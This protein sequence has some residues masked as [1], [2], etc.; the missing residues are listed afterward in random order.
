[1]S[2]HDMTSAEWDSLVL[3]ASEL[4]ITNSAG[5]V[6]VQIGPNPSIQIF[7]TNGV[8]IG[9]WDANGIRLTSAASGAS[10]FLQYPNEISFSV[11]DS[12]QTHIAFVAQG[13]TAVPPNVLRQL[14]MTMYSGDLNNHGG[15]SLL[16]TSASD[17]N[18][19]PPQIIAN[20]P[21]LAANFPGGLGAETWHQVTYA[22]NWSDQGSGFGKVAY[23][24]TP[25]GRVAF[26]G[27]AKLTGTS[28][29]PATV[30]SL[31]AGYRPNRTVNLTELISTSP[32][33]NPA[34]EMIQVATNGDV[35]VTCYAGNVNPGPI[36]FENLSFYL[37][38][39]V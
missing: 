10:M 20:Y 38:A 37:S 33:V 3:I 11:N 5:T 36:S 19:I 22:T 8:L 2:G 18:S 15:A 31:P 9:Q 1:M 4:L 6:L 13:S 26:S 21:I 23:R 30:F 34:T 35:F 17:D 7:D 24:F 27:M 29:A 28:A 32:T 12:D 25:D 39:P 14:Q 16:V